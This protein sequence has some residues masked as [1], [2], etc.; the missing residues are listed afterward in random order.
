MPYWIFLLGA[1]GFVYVLTQGVITAPIRRIYPPL[2]ECP[3][4]TGVWVGWIAASFLAVRD[5]AWFPTWLA[6]LVE[7]FAGGFA[8]SLLASVAVIV[9][10][11]VGSHKLRGRMVVKQVP[12][13]K[14]KG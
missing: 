9:L 10:C 12:P 13:T 4:C 3:M 14:K 7:V 11:T 8:I 5:K 6:T 1:A 2:L